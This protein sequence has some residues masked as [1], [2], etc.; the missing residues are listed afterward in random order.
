[1]IP[2]AGKSARHIL[3]S[4]ADWWPL[5]VAAPGLDGF[6]KFDQV[7]HSHVAAIDIGFPL[8]EDRASDG[9]FREPW[10]AMT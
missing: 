10:K 4:P 5:L 9:H 7:F 2:K 8:M 1:M 6:Q 3:A